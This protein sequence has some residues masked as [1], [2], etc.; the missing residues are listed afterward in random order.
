M[1]MRAISLLLKHKLAIIPGIFFGVSAVAV[2]RAWAEDLV[3]ELVENIQHVEHESGGLPQFDPSSFSSQ[4]VWLAIVF[5]ALYV[6][7]S[8]LSLPK[9]SSVL[10]TRENKIQGDR[11]VAEQMKNEA[12]ATLE[13]YEKSLGDARAEAARISTDTTQNIKTQAEQSLHAFKDKAEGQ[14]SALE[15]SLNDS[16]HQ[17]MDEMNTIAAEIASAAAEKIVGMSTDINQA[18]TVVQSLNKLSKAA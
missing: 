11:D 1:N 6:I 8:R 4:V 3:H 16:K 17:A 13:A 12:V 15:A 14:M 7:F 2:Q 5:V 10:E 18:K 9:I